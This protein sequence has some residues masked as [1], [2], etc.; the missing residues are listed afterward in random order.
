MEDKYL[1]DS[2]KLFL[3]PD[4][5]AQWLNAKTIDEKMRVFP[6]YVE[7]SPVGHCNHRC[8]SGRTLV[9]TIDGKKQIR[10]L[11]GLPFVP[12][13]TYSPEKKEVFISNAINIRK[14][15]EDEEVVRVWFT[16]TTYIDCTTD[17]KFM[18]IG[19]GK[20]K[21]DEQPIE[22]QFLKN[23][24]RV[25]AIAERQNDKGYTAIHW[26]RYGKRL[27]YRMIMDYVMGR[28]LSRTE[29]VHHKDHNKQNDSVE[30]LQYCSSASEHTAL[31]P[32]NTERMRNDNPA[33]KMNAEWRKK[34]GLSV[35][36]KVRSLAQRLNYRNSKLGIKNPNYSGVKPTNRTRIKET[37]HRIFRVE[38]LPYKEDV[39]CMEVP[40]TGWFFA[41]D[42]L[43]KNC[44]F[45]AVD[46]I[47]YKPRSISLDTMKTCIDSMSRNGVKSIMYAG[48][49]EPLLHKNI[50]DVVNY[51]KEAGIDV[52]FTTNGVLMT[53]KFVEECLHN[54][55]WVK[56][57]LN[58]GTPEAY[59][60]VH[61]T[62]AEDFET[63][64]SNI[65]YAATW[66]DI[67]ELK[68]SIG[69]QVVV[70]PENFDTIESLI[71]EAVVSGADYVVLKPYSQHHSS[72]NKYE[73]DYK[74]WDEQLSRLASVH[75]NGHFQVIYRRESALAT[76]QKYSKCYSTP[77]M[78]AYIMATGDVYSCSAYL[79]DERFNLGN[80]NE[81]SFEEIWLGDK[82]RK[83]LE[84]V[85]NELDISECRLNCRMDKANEYLWQLKN[86][87][88][89]HNF[90]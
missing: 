49:G 68:T 66:R 56:V 48:E 73:I 47:G 76:E 32:E 5:V 41:N 20:K 52:A 55:T 69:V 39:Y 44:T 75:S 72:V 83:N 14:V 53:D 57:S 61:Q 1:L 4:R 10:D 87:A 16:D 74:A 34:I 35:S 77:N 71:V 15:G 36:G 86:P 25:R 12:V 90:I 29:Q 84:F 88:P 27:R 51:T 17:H 79:L 54:V 8:L 30:N 67:H 65:S 24:D 18:Q 81:K 50:V 31:H 63:V 85:E 6:L 2:H 59:A 60:K 80:I 22:A 89:H 7:V 82:R 46:Y 11:I 78:W 26:G 19:L 42:V 40:A 37:N 13:Y 43:V 3:H 28:K 70:L 62:K 21:Q 9:N 58:A 64:L 45:C 23:G 38:K 33:K